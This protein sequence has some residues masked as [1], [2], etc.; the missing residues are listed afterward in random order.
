MLLRVC[1]SN[2]VKSGL[3]NAQV[4]TKPPHR[5]GDTELEI[6]LVSTEKNQTM[7]YSWGQER[8]LKAE[9]CII[10]RQ[11]ATTSFLDS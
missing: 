7:K 9:L 8:G 1:K 2:T 5:D 6:S 4:I 3:I 11:C 10:H